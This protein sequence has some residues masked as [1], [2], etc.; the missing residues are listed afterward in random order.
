MSTVQGAFVWYQLVTADVAASS[1]FYSAVVGWDM[2]EAGR[3][4]MN[5]T[6]ARVGQ[7]QVGGL[8]D[9]SPEG[10]I[11]RSAW[12]GFILAADVDAMIERIVGAGGKSHGTPA[13]MP[14]IGRM[15]MVADPQGAAFTLFQAAGEPAPD[16]DGTTT[17]AFGWHELHTTDWEAA[18]VFYQDLFGWEKSFAND[19][20][21]MGVYQTFSV[22]GQW[23]GGMMNIPGSAVPAWLYYITVDD[24]DSAAA[25]VA[26]AGGAVLHGPHQVPGGNWVLI[27]KDPQGADFA[28]AGSRA[29]PTRVDEE[30]AAA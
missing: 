13:D 21:P 12:T 29:G 19:M 6:L 17:G 7:R 14:G 28:L 11:S 22:A 1:A 9:F 24:I 30:R 8:T 27:A 20:G 23:T 25:R 26:A 2:V 4:G 3:S 16:L 15:A 18:F 5:Y 10:T